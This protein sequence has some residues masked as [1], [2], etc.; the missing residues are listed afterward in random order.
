MPL[1]QASLGERYPGVGTIADDNVV[2][3]LHIEQLARFKELPCEAQIFSTWR[4]VATRM[5]VRKE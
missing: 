1:E 4:W 3:N 5:V 2:V